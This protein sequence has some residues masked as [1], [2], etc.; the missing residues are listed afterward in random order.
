MMILRVLFLK[1]LMDGLVL[2]PITSH[3][4]PK[5]YN[6]LVVQ[7]LQEFLIAF[8]ASHAYDLQI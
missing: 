3:D 8:V 6:L 5:P 1:C 4:G 7:V 2:Y